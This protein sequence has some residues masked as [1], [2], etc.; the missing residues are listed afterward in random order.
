MNSDV[1]PAE[2]SRGP[3]W[4]QP[5]S[6]RGLFC[7]SGQQADAQFLLGFLYNR[8]RIYTSGRGEHLF[9]VEVGRQGL[10]SRLRRVSLV[11]CGLSPQR[12]G[13]QK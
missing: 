2:L 6:R 11:A 8:Y 7:N 12:L 4:R 9:R 10:F 5:S 3:A 13:K 1:E